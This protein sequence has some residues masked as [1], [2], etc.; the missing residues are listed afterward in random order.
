MWLRK[1]IVSGLIRGP[2][3]SRR[4]GSRALEKEKGVPGSQGGE[5]GD[6]QE[7]SGD[8]YTGENGL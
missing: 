8:I 5:K 1:L 3:P 7:I 2:G 6:I 4:K